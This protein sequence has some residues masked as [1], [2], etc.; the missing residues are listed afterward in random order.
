MGLFAKRICAA[1]LLGLL[2]VQ[3]CAGMHFYTE[4]AAPLGFM[5]DGE[6]RGMS[7]ELVHALIARTGEPATIEIVPWTR[8]Y[9]LAQRT[10]DTALFSTVRTAER[11]AS[12]QW[13]GP[14]LVG[15]SRFYSLK[16]NPIRVNTLQDAAVSGPLALPKKWYSYE[17]LQKMGLT[18]LYAVDS[19][20]TMVKMLKR[21][22]VN[23]IATQDLTLEQ[24]LATGGLV[25]ADVRAQMSFMTSA[26]Y[27]AFS[28][29]TDPAKVASWQRALDGMREDGS[30][31]K[32]VHK[33]L[34]HV[35]IT[36][37]SE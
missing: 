21:G 6:M 12:F 31:A 7:V 4:Q 22:R 1:V 23:L 8:G 36:R 5:Q 11:E 13:V 30:Y 18:N 34:P 2:S 25:P 15:S 17:S 33:W 14:I 28:P 35:D 9:Y 24:E 3:A 10:P 26:Y 29:S 27:I 19:P 20:K 16:N 37:A 32:I